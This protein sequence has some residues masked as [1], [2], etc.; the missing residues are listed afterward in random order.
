ML[1]KAVT[2]SDCAIANPPRQMALQHQCFSLFKN[3]P[4][5]VETHL[6]KGEI[7]ILINTFTR[8]LSHPL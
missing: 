5:A 8:V 6:L 3:P 4:Q 2:N 7:I 1:V